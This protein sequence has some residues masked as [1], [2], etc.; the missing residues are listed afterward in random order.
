[1]LLLLSGLLAWTRPVQGQQLVLNPI[2]STNLNV[3]LNPTLT[4]T[5]SVT[6]AV[7]A[8]TLIWFFGSGAPSG[9]SI[10]NSSDQPNTA[11]FTWTPTV[12]QVPSTNNITVQVTASGYQPGA[13]SF[14]VTVL[15]NTVTPSNTPSLTLPFSSTNIAVGTTLTFT[16]V[17]AVTDG[18]TNALLFGLDSS[19]VVAGASIG[20]NS[21]IF[22]WTPGTSAAGASYD[23]AVIVTET[24]TSPLLTNSQPFTVNVDP[25][26]NDCPQYG[27]VLAAV[28]T[29]NTNLV[30][31][32]CLTLVLTSTITVTAPNVT[33]SAST[34]NVT[35]A[36]NNLLRLFV[37]RPGASLTLNGITL[38]G[39]K[40]DSGGAI[41]NSAGGTIVLNNCVI[42]GNSAV[43]SSGING[44]N[45]SDDANYGKDA[46]SASSG[47][48]GVGGAILNLGDLTANSCQ[49]SN[50]TAAGG[51]GGNGGNGGSGS[52]RGGNGGNGGDGALAFGGAIYSAGSSLSL[53][54][55][56]FSG[57]SATGGVGGAGGT[58]GTGAFSGYMGTGGAGAEGSG[59]AVY[60]ANSAV[61]VNCTNLNNT[62]QGGSSAP[63]G[64]AGGGYG[65]KGASGGNSFGG[66]VCLVRGGEL[67]G[68]TFTN[69]TATGGNGGD[70]G[71]GNYSGGNGGNGG[72]A[73][74]GCLYN[75]GGATVV[76]CAFSGC[77]TIGGVNG[78]AGGGPFS[79][80]NGLPASSSTNASSTLTATNGFFA[81]G[82]P[83]VAL[84]A[85]MGP[86]NNLLPGNSSAAAAGSSDNA[87]PQA[88]S[89]LA[90]EGAL[91]AAA[92]PASNP[93]GANMPPNASP[94]IGL[95]GGPPGLSGAGTNRP[96][97]PRKP[98][99]PLVT[100]PGTVLPITP[101]NAVIPVPA[102]TNSP[103]EEML[104]QGMIDFRAADLTQV[105]DIYSMM[106]N[107]TI[108]RPATLPAP[109]ITLTTRG[110]LTVGEG[111]QAL[112]AVLALNGIVMVNVGDKFVK[113]MPEAQGG[114][115]GGR[116]DT[117]SA[118][119]YPE[120]GQF[121][122]HVV[123]LK[124]AKPSELVPVLTPFVKIPNAILA[125]DNSQMLVLRD[126]A[127]NI[128]RMLELID[129]I[130]V[131]IPSVFVSEVIPI[132]YGKASDIA[133]A[134]NSLSSGGG[135]TSMGGATGTRTSRSTGMN[136]AGGVGGVGGYPGQT[137]PG[138]VTPPGGAGTPTPPAGGNSFTSRL[139]GI[140][141]RASATGEIQ[142]LG[143]T[144]II[145]DERTNSLLIYAGKDDMKTIKEIIAKLD[146]VLAQVLIEAAIIEV[147]LTASR[148]LGL[149]YLQHPQNS[150]NWSGV[151]AVN[152]GN[153]LQPGNYALSGGTNTAGGLPSGFSY[154][155]SFGQ[156]LDVAVTAAASD[157]HARILQRPRIQTSH[158]EPA[159]LFVGTTQPYPTSSYYGG[160]A[161]GGST[162][163]QQLQIG[164]TLEV[165]P[166]INPDG[167]VVM[168]IHT[169]IDG[170]DGSVTIENV[171]QVPI[172]SS[173]EAASK[174][175]VRDHDTIILG[176]LIYTEKDKSAS[177][178]PVLMDIPLLG[179]LFRSSSA[180]DTRNEL[181]VLI[182]P[183]VL[184]TPE[185][186]ALAAT[187]EKNKMPGV[188]EVEKEVQ[189]DER[190]RLKKADKMDKGDTYK[191]L[192]KP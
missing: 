174:V 67:I 88:G 9:A 59:G 42:A 25:L 192:E 64:Q 97:L 46:T 33:L 191:P 52:Y 92:A 95:P 87:Q 40:S 142:V 186:A 27:D 113:A 108:L 77:V 19:G 35:I 14:I 173:K 7:N 89:P 63:S 167:L 118:A 109:T 181:I 36:G 156:D 107:R 122:T 60:S 10:T 29:G 16:A 78:A 8:N 101:T 11:V 149:S 123:Q 20:T 31:D 163:I 182:R 106:V 103:L 171:G 164:V 176:G 148:S 170:L 79:G 74:G 154:L 187:A 147:D 151:G 51:S 15:T 121:A 76:N 98:F 22:T 38:L 28:A 83:G 178:V 32:N 34:T 18:S 21:G 115:A 48:A 152:N 189:A 159:S 65:V 185:I 39:G 145:S 6:N 161:Y 94:A 50:N 120:M 26:T 110:Q 47:R 134:L 169:K 53:S 69:D 73:V 184:P 43:G 5:V 17:A 157:S 90:T 57:N 105:L 116:F 150:G 72:E 146:V 70:G 172:T 81:T 132:K 54:D 112:Q 144:K 102:A 175:S 96:A 165:T 129:T 138:M 66:G 3:S 82:L 114:S 128:K 177:G 153:F 68:C 75:F 41:Y 85:A 160:G 124:Y 162:S 45:G 117:N 140:I 168:D 139:Q 93:V 166:L 137:T 190:K 99:V 71:S 131:S 133:S 4:I 86:G 44:A 13:T 130:D 188:R 183:T 155:M 80:N 56:T 100:P 24:N 136:R 111:I 91:I 158:N 179:Y 37:V 119:Q 55:C 141:N 127:E 180:S 143:Q 2:S 84:P 1:M 49:F 62:A 125:I 126:Y 23:M 104:P 30:L 12:A 58:N 135:G 61:M